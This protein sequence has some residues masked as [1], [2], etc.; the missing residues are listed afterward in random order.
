MPDQ[1]RRILRQT[2]SNDVTDD[3]IDDLYSKG[4]IIQYPARQFLCKQGERADTFWILLDGCVGVYSEID[5]QMYQ[6]D[7]IR[8]GTFGELAILLGQLRTAFIMTLEESTVLELTNQDF[9]VLTENN[10]K[11]VAEIAKMVLGRLLEQDKKQLVKLRKAD[12]R[13]SPTTRDLHSDMTQ[14]IIRKLGE[15]LKKLNMEELARFSQQDF[16]KLLK[17]DQ[18]LF[19][20]PSE[21]SQYQTDIFMIMPFQDDLKPIYD[22]IKQIARNLNMT[23]KRGDDFFSH[24]TIMA[25]IWAV[26]NSA[27]LIICDCTGKN[28]NVFYELGIAHTLGKPT[29]IITQ[30]AA[31]IPFDLR[32]YRYVS[33]KNTW[34]G[35]EQF[36][37]ELREAIEKILR[38]TI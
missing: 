36:E 9:K 18:A 30:D 10:P 21:D 31:D 15:H 23:V 7:K 26:T 22:H 37:K 16:G 12:E 25:E 19:G 29:I 34:Q 3:A 38:L 5:D 8:S 11:I 2:F 4:Q 32:Q 13:E 14:N 17:K 6:I 24:S 28:P 33:Y 35:R 27:K 20:A 1:S